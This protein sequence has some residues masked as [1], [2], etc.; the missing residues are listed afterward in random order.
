M[1]LTESVA[2]PVGLSIIIVICLL[3]LFFLIYDIVINIIKNK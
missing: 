1:P 3:M 2:T